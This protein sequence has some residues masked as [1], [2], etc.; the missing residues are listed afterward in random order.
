MVMPVVRTERTLV[1]RI[2]KPDAHFDA[3]ADRRATR[4]VLT[5]FLA[6]DPQFMGPGDASRPLGVVGGSRIG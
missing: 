2:E 5:T 6:P 3:P 4:L 1:T